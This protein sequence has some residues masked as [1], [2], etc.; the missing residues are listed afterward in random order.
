MSESST[1]KSIFFP[2]NNKALAVTVPDY[3]RAFAWELTQI[4][5]FI[6]DL[7][8]YEGRTG[9]YFGHFIVEGESLGPWEI[10]DG[11]QRLTTFVLFLMVCRVLA[12][13][14]DSSALDLVEKFSTVSYDKAALKTINEKLVGLLFEHPSFD[15]KKPPTD[16][17]IVEHLD[18]PVEEFTRSQRRMVLA[19]LRFHQA[20]QQQELKQELKLEQKKITG[21]INVVMTSLCSHHLTTDKSVAVS[22]FE[23]HNTR[24]IPLTTLEIIKAMLMKFVYDHGGVKRDSKVECIQE[25]FG[26]IYGMEEQ[27]AASSFRGEMTMEQLL[28]LHL[29]VVDD[30]LKK[31]KAASDFD[32]PAINANADLLVAYVEER[33]NFKDREKS[34]PKD[35]EDGVLYALNLAKEFKKSVRIVSKILPT[36][37]EKD[38]LVGD[39]L[40]LERFLSCEFFLISCRLLQSAPD[41]AD[42]RIGNSTLL[43]WEKLLFT[44]DFHHLYHKKTYRDNFPELFAKCVT[45][46]QQITNVIKKYLADGFRPWDVTKGLQAIVKAF[47]NER[48]VWVLNKAFEWWRSKMIYAIYKYEKWTG[49]NIREVMKGGASVEHILPQEWD[50][51]KNEDEELKGMSEKERTE[52]QTKI[53]G[54]INGIGNLLLITP[55][56]NTR[57]NNKHPADK[58]YEYCAAGSYYEHNQSRERWRQSKEWP[59][60]ISERGEKIYDF[61]LKE[62]VGSPVSQTS[63]SPEDLGTSPEDLGTSPEDL[64]TS[65]EDLG[66][67]PEDLG[68]SPE[69]LGTSPEDLGTSPKDLGT[70]PEDLETSPEETLIKP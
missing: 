49:A 6:G 28:R 27:V 19:L 2:N 37:D 48:R 63:L 34:T 69:D 56:D 30:G 57:V 17:E 22:I 70:S 32:Y 12:K 23:M 61:M 36:W 5:L 46:E 38:D 41:K 15:A 7:Q 67:S 21:Y 11:Q 33:L 55:G 45:D 8:K 31:E 59:K 35:R 53:N 1:F 51:I 29:R 26:Q 58:E 52:F 43:H 24:G 3:Q 9:Y 40:I 64:G 47:L 4:D 62:L 65:P 18:L 68:T 10:V 42:G 20:F 16:K 25:E 14:L 13:E 54:C 66:T 44:R 60:L 50:W 39:V